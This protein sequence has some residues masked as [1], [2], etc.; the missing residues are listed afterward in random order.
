M[1]NALVKLGLLC[2]MA[3]GIGGTLY[4]EP[5][6]NS[7]DDHQAH[8]PAMSYLD[9]GVIRIG[10]DLALG[11]AIT[12][13][14]A[15]G[16]QTNLINSFDWGRQIQMSHYAGPI[17]FVP[18][19]KAPQKTWA[20]LG[21]NPIQAGDCY[22]HRSQVID[23]HN[24]GRELYVKCIPMQ[25]PLNNEPGECIFECWI[26][27]QDH[28]ALVRNRMVNHRSDQ[29]QY[30]GRHQELPAVY[31]CGPWWR[32]MTYTNDQPFAGDTPCQMP[33]R[34]PWSAW[35]ATENWAALID[36]NGWGL[37]IW[38]PGT[39]QFSGGFCDKPGTGGPRDNP[40]GY[41]TPLQ[42]EI[43]DHNIDYE[44][45][46]VLI[47]GKLADIR[48]YVYQHSPK[49]SPPVYRFENNR[50]HWYYVHAIDAGWPIHGELKVL[51]EHNDPQLIGPP[52]FWLAADAPQL[53]I[54]TACQASQPRATVF[55]SRFDAPGFSAKRSLAFDLVPDGRY[56][57]Y[58]V[59]L[60]A[61]P[62]YRGAITGLRFDP[63]PAGQPG[64]F[65]RLKSISLCKPK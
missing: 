27:L 61:S 46:Y 34:M 24:D 11:G 32:L 1:R 55:W 62:E 26:K 64:D 19:G 52:E 40:T 15:S 39:Y 42:T 21:W 12:Y 45:N 7:A 16:S 23:Q 56:H 3:H 4:A 8:I 33:A 6:W 44:F 28:T 54:E 20:G 60:A 18:H 51:L 59:N 50:Q 30:Q 63:V 58:A 47:L 14:S 41:M 31:T 2:L 29:T 57:V 35:Q 37:G 25:W 48:H 10:A 17:P 9:N 49:P 38:E 43:I 22:R 36:D 13:L 5:Q 65:I 53:Y